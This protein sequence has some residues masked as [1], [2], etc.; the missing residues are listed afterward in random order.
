MPIKVNQVQ[1]LQKNTY[2]YPNFST[3][4]PYPPLTRRSTAINP[5]S[6][7]N[8]SKSPTSKTKRLKI[9]DRNYSINNLHHK[10]H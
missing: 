8:V 6:S 10:N 5:Q 7:K 3:I 1:M 9:F 4:F 2:S